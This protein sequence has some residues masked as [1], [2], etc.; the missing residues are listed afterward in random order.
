MVVKSI[1]SILSLSVF[2][3]F[4]NF[5]T[6]TDDKLLIAIFGSLFLGAGIGITIADIYIFL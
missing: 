3:Y 6:V 1:S 4:E 2:I 5:E